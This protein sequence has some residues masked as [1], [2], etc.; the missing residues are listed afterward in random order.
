MNFLKI[1]ALL[2]YIYKLHNFSFLSSVH[3]PGIKSDVIMSKENINQM[4]FVV[5]LSSST[6]NYVYKS[7]QDQQ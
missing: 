3:G 2:L 7:P 5:L 1:L 6:I 4:L